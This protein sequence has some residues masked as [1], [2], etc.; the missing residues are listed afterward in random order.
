LS[1]P[2][3][4]AEV[5]QT[6]VRFKQSTLDALNLFKE[7]GP[8]T[9]KIRERIIKYEL[10]HEALCNIYN[11][12]Y[13]LVFENIRLGRGPGASG[14]SYCNRMTRTICLKNK[15]SVITYLHEFAH[16]MGGN[17]RRAVRWSCSL[18]KQT[19]PEKWEALSSNAHMMVRIR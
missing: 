17:E 5:M 6:E 3:S 10:L 1:Y 16:A 4:A 15:L 12:D 9:G 8:W 19:F 2:D 18:Y 13:R 11:I 14:S 7:S